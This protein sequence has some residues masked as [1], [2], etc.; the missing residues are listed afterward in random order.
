MMPTGRTD[1]FATHSN[2]ASM[3]GATGRQDQL[4][5]VSDVKVENLGMEDVAYFVLKATIVYIKQENFAYPACLNADCSKKLSEMGDGTWRCEK[6]DMAHPHPQWR[7]IMSVN[8]C[9]HTGQLWLSCFDEV[10]RIIMGKSADELV[11][12]RDEDDARFAAEFEAA[13]CRKLQF[14]CRAKMDTFGD[15]QR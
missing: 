1:T 8:V 4:K 7:Y 5:S 6:C 12:L 2:L 11:A 15:V 3:G 14:R 13:N 10:G 9:D